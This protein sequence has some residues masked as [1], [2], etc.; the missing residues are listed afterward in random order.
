MQIAPGLLGIGLFSFVAEHRT[1]R[2]YTQVPE[3]REI[4]D[5]GLGDAVAQIFGVGIGAVI[6]E[7][8]HGYRLD[9]LLV[10]LREHLIDRSDETVPLP[11]IVSTNAGDSRESRRAC[12]SLRIAVLT[13]IST[14]T[15]TLESHN[16]FAMSARETSSRRRSTKRM[17]R[18]IGWRSR[19]TGCPPRR[20]S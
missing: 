4:V 16:R 12:R 13:P 3:L 14:S 15:K 11:E 8:Q 9:G 2:Y 5:Q 17:S 19:W 10:T 1:A 18:S 7:G 20:S 6:G